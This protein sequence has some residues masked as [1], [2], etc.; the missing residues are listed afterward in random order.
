MREGTESSSNPHQISLEQ[1]PGMAEEVQRRGA[2]GGV[3]DFSVLCSALN[4]CNLQKTLI[5]TVNA[6][7]DS[8][9]VMRKNVPKLPSYKQEYLAR[10]FSL[11]DYNAHDAVGDV[12]MLESSPRQTL[13]KHSHSSDCHLL[14][15]IFNDEKSSNNRSLYVL[16]G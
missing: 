12:I 4:K 15:E 11:S 7:V 3:S 1:L 14:Q 6:F 10:Q 16:I 13:M 5:E 9:S 8:I 2:G